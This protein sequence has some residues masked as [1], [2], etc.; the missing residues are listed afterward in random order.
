MENPLIYR[1]WIFEPFPKYFKTDNSTPL[2]YLLGTY[3][4]IITSAYIS[5]ENLL[6]LPLETWEKLFIQGVLNNEKFF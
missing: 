5:A 4:E 2:L 6:L 3:Y 1:A